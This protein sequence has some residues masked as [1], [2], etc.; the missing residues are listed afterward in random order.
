VNIWQA[1]SSGSFWDRPDIQQIEA[2]GALSELDGDLNSNIEE[3]LDIYLDSL[4]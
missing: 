3:G 2:N 1:I 4:P